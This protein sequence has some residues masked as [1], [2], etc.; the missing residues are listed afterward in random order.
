LIEEIGAASASPELGRILDTDVG[1][2]LLRVVR[3]LHN[4]AGQP[5]QYLTVHVCPERSRLLME[6]RA[7]DIDTLNAGQMVHDPLLSEHG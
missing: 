2:P 3:L 7:E 1:A 6:I 5:V 4:A